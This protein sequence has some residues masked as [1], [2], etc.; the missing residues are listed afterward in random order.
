MIYLHGSPEGKED[1][2][3]VHLDPNECQ[4]EQRC[5]ECVWGKDSH[6]LPLGGRRILSSSTPQRTAHLGRATCG[7]RRDQ[8]ARD[9]ASAIGFY[10][11]APPTTSTRHRG[12]TTQN[13][14]CGRRGEPAPVIGRTGTET[15][16]RPRICERHSAVIRIVRLAGLLALTMCMQRSGGGQDLVGTC[17]PSGFSSRPTLA[18]ALRA[19]GIPYSLFAW[20]PCCT[21]RHGPGMNPWG[22]PG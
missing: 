10:E 3:R 14:G 11:L 4:G 7:T 20:L 12:V 22:W 21:A 17:P 16:R 18:E 2:K 13:P 19:S 15:A 8:L 9:V 1:C 5:N 6:A